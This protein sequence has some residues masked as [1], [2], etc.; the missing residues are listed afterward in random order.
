M[1]GNVWKGFNSPRICLREHDLKIALAGGSH[2]LTQ[3]LQ[4][5]SI[6]CV[7]PALLLQLI[8]LHETHG[9]L[10]FRCLSLGEYSGAK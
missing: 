2:H 3:V 4:L 5:K 9:R 1:D 6:C 7:Q 10:R 8:S